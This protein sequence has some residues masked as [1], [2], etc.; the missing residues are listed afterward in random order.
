M[1]IQLVKAGTRVDLT[2]GTNITKL[3]IGLG[4]DTNRY[5]GGH[6]FDLDVSVFMVD[7]RGVVRD[8]QDFIFYNNLAHPTGA[9]EHTGDNR[10]GEGDGD[11]ESVKVDFSRMPAHIQKLAFVVTIHDA[12]IRKQNFGLVMNSFVR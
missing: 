2:K 1:A 12:E 9:V 3:H 11:D 4:W 6:D 5:N 8:D 10:T 7:D